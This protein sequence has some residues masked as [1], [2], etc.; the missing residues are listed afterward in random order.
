MI[1]K[2]FMILCVGSVPKYY[3]VSVG[4]FKGSLKKKITRNF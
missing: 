2:D 3:Y 1:E 4:R